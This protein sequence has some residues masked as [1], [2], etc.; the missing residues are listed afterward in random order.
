[1]SDTERRWITV[2]LVFAGGVCLVLTAA[3]GATWA[4]A[5]AVVFGLFGALLAA[6][7]D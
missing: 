5:A 7:I 6:S 3:V 1:M 4:V 2:C